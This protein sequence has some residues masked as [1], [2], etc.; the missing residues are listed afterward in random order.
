MLV[1]D[2]LLQRISG[3]DDKDFWGLSLGSVD[4]GDQTEGFVAEVGSQEWADEYRIRSRIEGTVGSPFMLM[5]TGARLCIARYTESR[6]PIRGLF[7]GIPLWGA[8]YLGD[9]SSALYVCK[10]RRPQVFAWSR[11]G[12]GDGF[13]QGY[14]RG[15]IRGLGKSFGVCLVP[16][17]E[18]PYIGSDP[19]NSYIG[20]HGGVVLRG[21]TW[22]D[23]PAC[24]WGSIPWSSVNNCT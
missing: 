23:S 13:V 11:L 4:V 14:F 21:R 9:E 5:M 12:W 15:Y 19:G 2:K 24:A 6:R 8:R 20:N 3:L 22:R 1:K 17:P 16:D 10:P 18:K 7:P